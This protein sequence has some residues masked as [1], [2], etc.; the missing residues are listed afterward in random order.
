MKQ[1]FSDLLAKVAEFLE[2]LSAKK[3]ESHSVHTGEHNRSVSPATLNLRSRISEGESEQLQ[4]EAPVASVAAESAI[5]SAAEPAVETVVVAVA[6]EAVQTEVVAASVSEP[7]TEIVVETVAE[8]VVVVTPVNKPNTTAA[9]VADS[10][11]QVPEDSSLRRH[12][13]TQRRAEL[14]ADLGDEPSDST[15]KRHYQQLVAAKISE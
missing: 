11:V 6:E 3:T 4:A 1:L 7:V 9:V 14:L 8:E 2:Q 5:E 15:L 10:Q 13:L 12:Y